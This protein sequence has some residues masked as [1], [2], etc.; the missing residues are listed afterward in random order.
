M[1]K[2][3]LKLIIV[4][5]ATLASFSAF[6]CPD[7]YYKDNFGICWPYDKCV[8]PVI[9]D[10]STEAPKKAINLAVALS[11]GDPKIINQATGD[12]LLS[13][14]SCIGCRSLAEKILPELTDEQING[15]V[16]R[17]FFIFVAT[18][19]PVLV[20]LD[21]A[22]NIA[23]EQKIRR[24]K[25]PASIPK[26][27]TKSTNIREP[28]TFTAIAECIMKDSSSGDIYAAWKDPA[29]IYG[30]GGSKF[31]YPAVDLFAG[32]TVIVTAPKC[33][34][35]DKPNQGQVGLTSA[36]FKFEAVSSL[37]GENEVLK[38][39]MYGPSIQ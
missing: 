3:A 20:T 9:I 32:D 29:I 22:N 2:Y 39:F 6:A 7:C 33:A 21:A 30:T 38:W 26:S 27:P 17:G 35:W 10:T 4:T 34:D 36:K 31:K 23:K 19:D 15:I 18:N 1:K 25:P 37:A 14:T 24:N 5:C 13:S 8:V 12:L 28:K 16:G 11:Q